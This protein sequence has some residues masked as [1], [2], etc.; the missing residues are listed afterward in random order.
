[1]HKGYSLGFKCVHTSIYTIKNILPSC[2]PD[3][4]PQDSYVFGSPVFGSIIIRTDPD[5]YLNPSINKQM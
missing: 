1:M 2:T 4:N 3:P 5:P